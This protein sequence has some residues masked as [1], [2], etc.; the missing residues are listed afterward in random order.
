[1]KYVAPNVKKLMQTPKTEI[2]AVLFSKRQT[3][4]WTP[5]LREFLNCPAAPS[6]GLTYCALAPP[7]PV[8]S[9]FLPVS[10]S[11]SMDSD[12]QLILSESGVA[13]VNQASIAMD[14]GSTRKFNAL[15]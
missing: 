13:L 15:D 6:A 2:A 10:L 1:M 14:Y 7:L 11:D 3:G 4:V 12:L 5:V 8:F 9:C